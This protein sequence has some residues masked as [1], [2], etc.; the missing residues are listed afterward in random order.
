LATDEAEVLEFKKPLKHYAVINPQRH[1]KKPEKEMGM[2]T[3]SIKEIKYPQPYSPKRLLHALGNGHCVLLSNFTLNENNEFIFL[4]ASAFTVDVDDDDKITNPKE[5]LEKLKH[6]CTGLFPTFSHGIKGNRYRLFF[7]LDQAITNEDDFKALVDCVWMH[8][9]GLGIP[10]DESGALKSP[11][12]II[13]P[14]I[15]GYEINDSSTTLSVSKWMPIAKERAERLQKERDAEQKNRAKAFK[16]TIIEAPTY[17]EMKEMCEAIGYIP[18]GEGLKENWYQ[19]VYALKNEVILGNLSEQEGFELYCIVSGNEGTERNWNGLKPRGLVTVGSIVRL[20]KESG[21]KRKHKYKY[22]MR[23]TPEIIPVEHLKVNGKLDTQTMKKLIQRKQSLLID[24]PTGS[25]KTFS[26]IDA[27]KELNKEDFANGENFHY[28]I[29]SAPTIPLTEQVA[30][31]YD[32]VGITG[33]TKNLHREM[34]I[35]VVKHGTRVFACT[36]DKTAEIIRILEEMFDYAY[37][38]ITPKFTVVIDEMHKFTEAYNYRYTAI[39][40]IKSIAEKT[41]SFI[42]ISGTCEDILKDDFEALIKIDTGN[43]KSPCLNY[44]VF[45]YENSK[46]DFDVMLIPVIRGLLKQTR[47][48]LFINNKKRI[49]RIKDILRKEGIKTQV[50]TSD[51]KKSPTYMDVVENE[52]IADDIQVLITT[53][54]LADGVNIQ[55]KLQWSCLVVSD[56][57]SPFF[58]PSTIKQI[59]NRFRG[60]YHYFVLY[61]HRPNPNHMD[62][63]RFNIETEYRYRK[64]VVSN[65]VDYLN[66]EFSDDEYKQFMPSLIEKNNGIYY[67]SQTENAIISFNPLFVRHESMKRKENFYQLFR[68]AFIHEVGKQLGIEVSGIYSVNEEVEKNGSD[69]SKL[70]EIVEALQEQ[71]KKENAELRQAFSTFFDQDIYQAFLKNDDELLEVFKNYVHPEQFTATRRNVTIADFEVCKTVGEKI[72][73]K[74]DTNKYFNQIKAL[75]DIAYF[76]NVSKKSVTKKVYQELMKNVGELYS[77]T[78]FKDLIE[79]KLP[80]K[81][82]VQPKDV[83]DGLQLF[84]ESHTRVTKER[85][86]QITP[87]TVEI[88]AEVHSIPEKAV[89]NSIIK[90]VWSKNEHQQNI[91]L[92]AIQEKWGIETYEK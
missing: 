43:R 63:N 44:R 12:Q 14:G 42:G 25:G 55:N 60:D 61:M 84:H 31:K 34:S 18:S 24:S 72:K 82:K 56:S 48:L 32:V 77:S 10:V 19:V 21:Y 33:E 79:K 26:S 64:N 51:S 11:T 2:V 13:R 62:T 49:E 40:K 85:R 41:V 91:L 39:D 37:D 59:S 15:L 1:S 80:K 36:Y 76:E 22:A 86:V 83:K 52:T 75:A 47:V 88:V 3:N 66:Q 46:T 70:F 8:L 27:F 23:E 78:D 28:Y 9:K 16:D 67:K 29:F 87:L 53:S 5:V 68:N 58:N 65:Y 50:V 73:R 92:S 38:G 7:Q 90:Y 71:E 35:Q 89:R 20:A 74:A 57:S 69:L 30:K 6:I 4:S 54:V 45:T 81:L 17:E